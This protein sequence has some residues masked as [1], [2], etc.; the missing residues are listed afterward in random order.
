MGSAG[1][2][3]RDAPHDGVAV[4]YPTRCA[5]ERYA[6]TNEDMPMV[7]LIMNVFPGAR[8]RTRRGT[9]PLAWGR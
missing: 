2:R 4:F 6:T 5:L 7:G 9:R 3:W 8:G 1:N